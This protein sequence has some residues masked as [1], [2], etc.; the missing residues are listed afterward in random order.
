MTGAYYI[1][2][3]ID[4]VSMPAVGPDILVEKRQNIDDV[5]EQL[6]SVI[7]IIPSVIPQQCNPQLECCKPRSLSLL[8]VQITY[9]L[10]LSPDQL[11]AAISL[12]RGRS[13]KTY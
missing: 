9:R 8:I 12:R 7:R 4:E 6:A 13:Q 5:Q 3:V 11:S 1:R 2:Q 10:H